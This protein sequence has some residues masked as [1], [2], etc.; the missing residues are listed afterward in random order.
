MN[1]MAIEPKLYVIIGI[2]T[3]V[4]AQ[5]SLKRAGGEQSF[6]IAWYIW[7]ILSAV[8]YAMS[9]VSYYFSLKH[10]DISTVQPIMMISIVALIT[11][12]G[13]ISGESFSYY[14][15]MGITVSLLS[16]YLIFKS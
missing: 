7:L 16:I 8:F 11:V 12:Y 6:V 10:F 9:F 13:F 1:I 14:K 15:I 2:I 3:T 4:I 5:I